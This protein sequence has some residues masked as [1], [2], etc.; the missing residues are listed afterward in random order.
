MKKYEYTKTMLD[1]YVDNKPLFKFE[2]GLGYKERIFT[3]TDTVGETF[4]FDVFIEKTSDSKYKWQA[5][6]AATGLLIL[7]AKTYAECADNVVMKAF[8]IYKRLTNPVA[9]PVFDMLRDT[10]NYVPKDTIEKQ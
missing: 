5:T 10:I 8:D 7:S 6:H 9:K 1:T 3:S 2:K 4:E